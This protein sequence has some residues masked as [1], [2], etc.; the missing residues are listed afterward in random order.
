[1]GWLDSLSEVESTL[2]DARGR[3]VAV[4]W[5]EM[6]RCIGADL[7]SAAPVPADAAAWGSYE[8]ALRRARSVWY[9]LLMSGLILTLGSLGFLAAW[10][11]WSDGPLKASL[12][13]VAGL[14]SWY[15]AWRH[16]RWVKR[17]MWVMRCQLVGSDRCFACAYGMS[18]IQ[19]EGDGCMV[20]PEC[21]AAW[22]IDA[23][24]SVEA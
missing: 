21:G 22:R 17:R 9:H 11:A 1:M 18:G 12:F 14:V 6:D 23:Q 13:G 20:C 7:A 19:P 15:V 16:P 3:R 10:L 24:A 5:D 2:V 4:R 8:R